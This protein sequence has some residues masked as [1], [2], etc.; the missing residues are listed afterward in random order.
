CLLR[1]DAL[2]A[3][4]AIARIGRVEERRELQIAATFG[5][6]GEIEAAAGRH[7][8]RVVFQNPTAQA[9]VKVAS[10]G[11]NA[12]TDHLRF[13]PAAGKLPEVAVV[14]ISRAVSLAN[15]AG[16]EAGLHAVGVARDDQAVDGLHA[17]AVLHELHGEPIEQFGVR[18]AFAVPAEVEDG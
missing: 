9:R 6:D 1:Y 2:G 15:A 5:I 17:P 4:V 3:L 14:G 13:G 16:S 7:P 11:E 18:G 12:V 10:R 8:L